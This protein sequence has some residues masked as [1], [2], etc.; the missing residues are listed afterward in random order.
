MV[1]LSNANS[2]T[3]DVEAN[4]TPQNASTI[5]DFPTPRKTKKFCRTTTPKDLPENA[6]TDGKITAT[7]HPNV[8]KTRGLRLAP[9]DHENRKWKTDFKMKTGEG[10]IEEGR[11]YRVSGRDIETI[12][13]PSQYK[14]YTDVPSTMYTRVHGLFPHPVLTSRSRAHNHMQ[15]WEKELILKQAVFVVITNVEPHYT[16]CA[17]ALRKEHGIHETRDDLE[18]PEAL[19]LQAAFPRIDQPN[20]LIYAG[21]NL[22]ELEIIVASFGPKPKD[23][24]EDKEL[25]FGM[26]RVESELWSSL[27]LKCLPPATLLLVW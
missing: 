16:Q 24:P 3:S 15:D 21:P 14:E 19:L 5:R 23:K 26:P 25:T 11:P 12:M 1:A 9:Y 22:W 7:K 20:Y 8:G 18:D 6:E 2:K 17:K 13:L 27:A 10:D 4:S